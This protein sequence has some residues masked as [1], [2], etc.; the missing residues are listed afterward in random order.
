ME[1]RIT[2]GNPSAEELAALCAVLAATPSDSAPP[3]RP[4][5]AWTDPARR[6]GVQRSWRDS[7]LPG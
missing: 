6:L 5:S 7:T 4:R 2:A 1:L 3:R